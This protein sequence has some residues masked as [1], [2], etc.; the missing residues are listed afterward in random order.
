MAK[1]RVTI[2][3]QL[4][5]EKPV[6][7][8]ADPMEKALADWDALA[9]K[10]D[11]AKRAYIKVYQI[12]DEGKPYTAIFNAALSEKDQ[13][14]E[15]VMSCPDVTPGP[16]MF[17]ARLICDGIKGAFRFSVLV[18]AKKSSG[19]DALVTVIERLTDRLERL[20]RAPAAAPVAATPP[21]QEKIWDLLMTRMVDKLTAD[22]PVPADPFASIEKFGKVLEMAREVGGGGDGGGGAESNIYDVIK[23]VAPTLGNMLEQFVNAR[24]A[25]LAGVPP[26]AMPSLPAPAIPAAQS[27][28]TMPA[29]L[30]PFDA[31]AVTDPNFVGW[32]TLQLRQFM[33]RAKR[34]DSVDLSVGQVL[35]DWQDDFLGP[36]LAAPDPIGQ[37]V[38]VVPGIAPYRPWFEGLLSGVRAAMV[39]EAGTEAN[40]VPVSAHSDIS[41]GA[42]RG[43]GAN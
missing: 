5:A 11:P 37:L 25:A 24:A 15:K 27:G 28:P 3:R 38:L 29:E 14:E 1:R 10:F 9:A 20:E 18:P 33:A 34:G 17:E 8:P 40:N 39:D 41:G 36:L 2:I 19:G 22:P 26:G 7:A 32:V 4:P 6:P 42:S 30:T 21:M 35:E 13:L 23:A 43:A 31:P 16:G 12:I